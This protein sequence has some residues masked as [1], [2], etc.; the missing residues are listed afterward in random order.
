MVRFVYTQ[1][2][3]RLYYSLEKSSWDQKALNPNLFFADLYSLLVMPLLPSLCVCTLSL[4]VGTLFWEVLEP[5]G[6][7]V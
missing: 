4:P 5:G 1:A 3:W 7:R 2:E 6:D